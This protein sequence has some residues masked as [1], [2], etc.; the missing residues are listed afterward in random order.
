MNTNKSCFDSDKELMIWQ[1]TNCLQCKKAVWYNQRLKKM[2]QYRCAIQK[3]IEAQAAGQTEINERTYEAT[4]CKKCTFFK[5]KGETS[6]APVE[7][8]D[9]SKGESLMKSDILMVTEGANG[10]QVLQPAYYDQDAPIPLSVVPEDDSLLGQKSLY[11]Q[12]SDEEVREMQKRHKFTTDFMAAVDQYPKDIS[13]HPDP[14]LFK[15]AMETGVDYDA[16]KDAERRMFDNI[17]E[18]GQLPPVFTETNFKKQVKSDVHTML[19]TFTW[20]ENMMIAFVPLVISHIAWLYAEKVMKYCADHRIPET[21]KLSRVVKHVRQEYV[22]SLKKDL[23]AKH[24]GRI[25]EQTEQFCKLYANDFTIMWY[26]VNS[27]FCKCYPN[28]ELLPMRTDAYVSILLCRFLVAHNKRMDKIIEAKIGFAQS[29]KNPYMD[30]L[31]TCMDAYC[32]EHTIQNTDNINAC[33]RILEKNIKNI[34]FE[35]DDSEPK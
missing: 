27:E 16:L 26:L 14:I 24:I 22:D 20:E 31:E 11:P 23:D 4:R 8:L 34:N 3:Q 2:P 25:E 12:N 13:T 17:C 18:K 35:I 19:E 6:D 28:D 21:V 32:G 29:I 9:F 15:L 33:L 30:K 7:V 1:D 5:S 10:K